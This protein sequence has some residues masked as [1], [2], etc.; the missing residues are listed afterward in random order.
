M[1]DYKFIKREKLS[2]IDLLNNKREGINYICI[3]TKENS[4]EEFTGNDAIMC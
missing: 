2:Y 3:Q 1:Y 4:L